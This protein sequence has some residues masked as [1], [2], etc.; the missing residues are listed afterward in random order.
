MSSGIAVSDECIDRFNELRD[1]HKYKFVIYKIADD[2]K[3][4]V[5][6]STSDDTAKDASGNS[7]EEPEDDYEK[8]IGRFPENDGRYA[9]YDFDY[10]RDGGKRNKVLFFTW[11]PDNAPVKSKML[12]ASSKKDIEQRLTGTALVIQATDKDDLFYDSVLD[13]LN[14]RFR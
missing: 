6:E 8:F 13:T 7:K 1:E 9:V 2:L 14:S 10:T 5:V 4:I 12:Y 3:S 11:A